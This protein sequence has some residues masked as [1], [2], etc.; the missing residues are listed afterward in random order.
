MQHDAYQEACQFLFE[1]LPMFQRVGAKA[2]KNDLTNIRVLTE[3]L[4]NPEQQFPSLHIGGTNGKGSVTHMLSAICQAAGL[5]TGLYVSPHYKDF[6]ERIRINGQYIPRREVVDFVH[7][8][9]PLMEDVRPS[10]FEISVAMAFS[11]F[12]KRKVDMAVVEVGLGGRL[13]STNILRPEL[14]VITNISFDHVQF[15][16]DTYALIAGEKAG[17]IKEGVPVVIGETQSETAPVFE[18]K[19]AETKAAICF[20]D[21]HYSVELLRSSLTHSWYRVM[22]DGQL[23]Y[24]ELAL[25]ATGPYQ[26]LNLQTTLAAVDQWQQHTGRRISAEAVRYAL[27]NLRALT[28]FQGRWQPLRE[29]P[30]VIADSAHNEAGLQLALTAVN[31]LPH[32][33]LHIV[34]GM[35]NDK[36]REKVWPL[37][38]AKARYYWV[39]AN[40][41]RGLDAGELAAEAAGKGLQGKAY[42]SVR[43]GYKAAL[44]AASAQDLILICG[45]IFV[46]AEVL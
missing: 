6:R 15:L 26:H 43:N 46:T 40:V 32:D 35:V 23:L 38:P 16:G 34:F 21:Q 27:A 4:G 44:R 29:Q 31:E 37:L 45:S 1:Q 36:D 18:Q 19:A 39:K 2:Y 5:R 7:T 25:N 3:R 42:S 14:S 9:R 20:A 33:Q 41:P 30:L 10:F 22:R 8:V 13:D 28:R 17:I 11:Y 24:D 12:A